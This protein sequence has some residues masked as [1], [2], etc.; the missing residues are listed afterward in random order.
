MVALDAM[1]EKF[2][3][4]KAAVQKEIR[5]GFFHE[6]G[7]LR[8]S[9][10]ELRAWIADRAVD[11]LKV[12]LQLSH[13]VSKC[14][15]VIPAPILMRVTEQMADEARHFNILRSLVPEELHATIDAKVDELP[16]ALAA[17]RHW[18]A[19]SA[20]VE[21]GNPYAALLDINIVHEGYSA[22]AIE[23]LKEIPFE[24][25]RTAY[26]EIGADEDKHHESGR[27]LLLW[28]TEASEDEAPA[29]SVH[30]A[31][32]VADRVVVDAHERAVE[33]GALNWSWPK[34][35]PAEIVEHAHE[36]VTEGA[37][38]SWSWPAASP[39]DIVEHAHVRAVEGAALS[40]SW[41]AAS[42]TDPGTT[43]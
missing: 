34:T 12:V 7:T 38:L 2:D 19:L 23:E 30:V 17:D 40:W 31:T 14:A 3:A 10:T 43:A 9:E 29:V 18:A 36:R 4:S 6:D 37:A 13:V 20:A 41:P 25:I 16:R 32:D 1:L 15:Q 27:D 28:L 5:E 8:I 35:S 24:D 26:R 33:G 22:A 21:Q 39:T 42:P 11:E